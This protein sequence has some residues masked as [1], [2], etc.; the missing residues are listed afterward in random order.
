MVLRKVAISN[1]QVNANINPMKK[2]HRLKKD[3]NHN[4]TVQKFATKT[5]ASS[6]KTTTI[7]LKNKHKP[8]DSN[9]NSESE[10]NLPIP[11]INT[12][13][14]AFLDKYPILTRDFYQIDA[15]DL[16][17]RLLGKF[18]RR[19]DIVLQITEVFNVIGV[20]DLMCF[21][22]FQCSEVLMLLI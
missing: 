1:P 13:L 14:I 2:P 6:S 11:Q 8:K 18:L 3:S 21:V 5:K 19:D 7:K 15:L 12:T 4:I 20:L 22:L 16:A 17:P 10:E 9:P